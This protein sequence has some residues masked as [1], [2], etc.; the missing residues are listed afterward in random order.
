MKN[1]KKN[2]NNKNLIWNFFYKFIFTLLLATNAF[3]F[4]LT[5][6][7]EIND[8]SKSIFCESIEPLIPPYPHV[9]GNAELHPDLLGLMRKCWSRTI[10]Q[11]PDATLARKITDATLKM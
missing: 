1:K 9:P 3:C 8:N 6:D 5:S 10:D 2:N 7:I 4:N 11:R